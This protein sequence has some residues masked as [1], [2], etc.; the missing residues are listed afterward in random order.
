MVITKKYKPYKD[1]IYIKM[2]D[3]IDMY[4]KAIHD[5]PIKFVF[6]YTGRGSYASHMLTTVPGASSS[7]LEVV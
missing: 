2:T 6:F 7:I 1:Y 3:D 4:V 5:S